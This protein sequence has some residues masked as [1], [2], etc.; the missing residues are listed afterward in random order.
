MRLG[1]GLAALLA[2][3]GGAGCAVSGHGS[4]PDRGA[5]AAAAQ[6]RTPPHDVEPA[7]LL[8]R[9]PDDADV[10]LRLSVA[11]GHPL[12][13]RLEPFILA[14]PGWGSTLRRFTVH[15]VTELDWIEIVGPRDPTKERLAT[16]TTMDDE[17][18]DSR[19]SG[20]SDGTLRVASRAQAHLVTA[21]PPAAAE[22]LD[23]TC[24]SPDASPAATW[25]SHRPLARRFS[26]SRN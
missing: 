1:A 19:L 3:G 6:A 15:P 8:A 22:A 25:A 14:W 11:R 9:T 5:A 26:T 17:L 2:C 7:V 20:S 16:R 23:S 12:G 24:S 10:L 21:V 18:V 13:P 4:A